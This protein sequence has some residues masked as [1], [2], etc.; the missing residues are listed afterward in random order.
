MAMKSDQVLPV[1]IFGDTGMVGTELDRLLAGHGGVRVAFRQN[2]KRAEGRLSA[3][4]LAFLATKDGESMLFARE[5]IDA[6]VRVVDM[7][8]A[9]RLGREAFERWYGIPHTAPELLCEAVYGLPALNADKIRKA[10]LVANPGCYPTA[11]ILT[12]KPLG[13]LLSGEAVIVATSGNSGARREA[14]ADS[15]EI[16]YSFGTAHKHVPEMNFYA[17]RDVDFTPIVLRSV[18]RGINANIR[19]ALSD[20]LRELEPERAA[21]RIEEVIRAAYHEEDLVRVVRDTP[22]RQ[23]G[24]RD[25]VGTNELIIKARVAGGRAYLCAML[26]NLVKGAAGQAIENMNLMLGL[27]RLTGLG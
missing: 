20:G 11:V 26:D 14:E 12:L 17:E 4:A 25:V 5:A 3:C 8:G 23:W 15:N 13:A 10:R 18:F 1:G 7:S 9:F 6:G 22:E 16:T 2:S 21:E 27:P 19:V 24:T